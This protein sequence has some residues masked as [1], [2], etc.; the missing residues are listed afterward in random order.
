[1]PAPYP[2]QA[3]SGAVVDPAESEALNLF[4]QY[5]WLARWSDE[6]NKDVD[7]NYKK[8]MQ[9]VF[10]MRQ[11]RRWYALLQAKGVAALPVIRGMFFFK[12]CQWATAADMTADLT[13]IY[14]ECGLLFDWLKLNMP[15]ARTYATLKM[16]DS[17]DLV[18]EPITAVKSVEFGTRIAAFR[19]LFA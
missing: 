1:M 8:L 6:M 16:N 15:E 13:A 18:D 2:Y 10:H 17:D 3:V 9:F 19:G 7:L 4:R 5:E 11:Y 12:K 14:A